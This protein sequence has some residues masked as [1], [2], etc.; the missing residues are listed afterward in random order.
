[1]LPG[2]FV[3]LNLMLGTDIRDSYQGKCRAIVKIIGQQNGQDFDWDDIYDNEDARAIVFDALVD[4]A[5]SFADLNKRRDWFVDLINSHLESPGIDM[6]EE[7]QAWSITPE[8]FDEFFE[9]LMSE[10]RVAV[11]M[12]AGRSLITRRRDEKTTENLIRLMKKLGRP[13]TS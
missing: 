5:G 4:I 11:S 6:D 3:A 12:E 13:A 9:A 2:F 7:S 8:G 1:M 10:L